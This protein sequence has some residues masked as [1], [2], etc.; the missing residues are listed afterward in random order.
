MSV[1]ARFKDRPVTSDG[2]IVP[3]T[4]FVM[5]HRLMLAGCVVNS[6]Q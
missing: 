3:D 2:I 5:K 4:G 1:A 6:E